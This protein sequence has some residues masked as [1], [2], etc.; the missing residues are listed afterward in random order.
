MYRLKN[1]YAFEMIPTK[2]WEVTFEYIYDKLE[3]RI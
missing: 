2:D 3:R 1:K